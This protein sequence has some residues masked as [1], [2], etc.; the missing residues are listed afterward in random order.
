M[1]LKKILLFH[2]QAEQEITVKKS[3]DSHEVIQLFF[4][5]VCFSNLY[6]WMHTLSVGVAK[7]VFWI[8]VCDDDVDLTQVQSEVFGTPL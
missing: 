2:I 6:S 1:R 8:R 7:L 4:F 3:L 5:F